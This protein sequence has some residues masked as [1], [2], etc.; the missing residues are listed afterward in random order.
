MAHRVPILKDGWALVA[1]E[2]EITIRQRNLLRDSVLDAQTARYSLTMATR[3]KVVELEQLR[4]PEDKEFEKR[5]TAT[6]K[7]QSAEDRNNT[8]AL[9]AFRSL[10]KQ[11]QDNISNY[12]RVRVRCYLRGWHLEQPIPE[13]DDD[14]ENLPEVLFDALFAAADAELPAEP[15]LSDS[16]DSRAD[17][18][19]LVEN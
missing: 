3:T 6:E 16:P 9:L 11:D 14:F 10:S 8:A 12:Q 18:K 17:P 15:D 7:K 13:S 19:A 2:D 5:L 4:T 1:D